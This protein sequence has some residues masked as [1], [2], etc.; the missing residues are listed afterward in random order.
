MNGISLSRRDMVDDFVVCFLLILGSCQNQNRDEH[1]EDNQEPHG[2]SLS[3][4]LL[5]TSCS[6]GENERILLSDF[7]ADLLSTVI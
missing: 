2:V 4:Y 1:D 3:W 6:N 5:G 7:V